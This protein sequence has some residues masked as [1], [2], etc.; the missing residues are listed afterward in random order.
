MEIAKNFDLL[1]FQNASKITGNKFVFLKNEAALLELA[2]TNWVINMV[3][4]RGYEPVLT[5]DLA[6]KQYIEAC[7]F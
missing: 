2:L 5:P 1:D 3:S 6:R 4:K 7:G